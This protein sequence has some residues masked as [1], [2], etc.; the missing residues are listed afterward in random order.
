VARDGIPVDRWVIK[1][2]DG[3][4]YEMEL[5]EE[6]DGGAEVA[7]DVSDLT[8]WKLQ[9]RAGPVGTAQGAKV[10]D[11]EPDESLLEEDVPVIAFDLDPADVTSDRTG[12]MG[13]LQALD[14]DGLPV[15][16]TTIELEITD[17][18]TA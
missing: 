16:F 8:D 9:F 12:W 1:A 5:K 15:T 13:D 14:A 7:M 6:D 4:R 3:H 11:T 17:E 10:F 18:Y 2:G